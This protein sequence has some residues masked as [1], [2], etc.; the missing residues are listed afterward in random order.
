MCLHQSLYLAEDTLATAYIG[1]MCSKH[2]LPEA[3]MNTTCAHIYVHTNCIKNCRHRHCQEART[4]MYVYACIHVA[5]K[6]RH[7][8][9]R[10]HGGLLHEKQRLLAPHPGG[11]GHGRA[12]VHTHLEHSHNV[13]A[14]ALVAFLEEGIEVLHL[15]TGQWREHLVSERLV[16]RVSQYDVSS[17]PLPMNCARYMTLSRV[18]QRKQQRWCCHQ[19]HRQFQS[20]QQSGRKLC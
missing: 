5:G 10:T 13:T 6:G 20:T 11:P 19:L 3:C 16:K 12:G 14:N 17:P 1:C 4:L 9:P 8:P 7:S 15:F 18:C 2:A